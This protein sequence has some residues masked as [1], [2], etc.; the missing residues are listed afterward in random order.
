MVTIFTYRMSFLRL[1]C[2]NAQIHG[3]ATPF[4]RVRLAFAYLCV[5]VGSMRFDRNLGNPTKNQA[6]IWEDSPFATHFPQ[7]ADCSLSHVFAQF[8]DT[9]NLHNKS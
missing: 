2:F 9:Q 8:R 1:Y 6:G 7:V 5:F 4:R 3:F